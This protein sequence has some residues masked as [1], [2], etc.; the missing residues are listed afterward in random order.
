MSYKNVK[1]RIIE[2][3]YSTAKHISKNPE[4]LLNGVISTYDGCEDI[5]MS[6]YFLIERNDNMQDICNTY[7]SQPLIQVNY[8]KFVNLNEVTRVFI[9]IWC[10]FVYFSDFL[11]VIMIFSSQ[12]QTDSETIDFLFEKGHINSNNG[13]ELIDELS[14][15]ISSN[16]LNAKTVKRINNIFRSI[17]KNLI[18]I[19]N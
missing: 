8:N 5:N 10:G 3:L 1:Y 15:I 16:C 17:R 6:A 2:A 12:R 9:I 14:N 11:N 19:K 4:M 7:N 18:N 13:N